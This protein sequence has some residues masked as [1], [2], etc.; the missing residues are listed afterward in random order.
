MA[1]ADDGIIRL[2]RHQKDGESIQAA[3]DALRNTGGRV[4]LPLG[5]YYVS[6]PIQLYEHVSLIGLGAKPHPYS[7]D[8]LGV[9]LKAVNGCS[10]LVSFFNDTNTR[11]GRNERRGSSVHNIRFNGN[12]VASVGCDISDTVSATIDGCNFENFTASGSAVRAGGALFSTITNNNM[13]GGDYYAL[14]SDATYSVNY[15][16]ADPNA[17]IYY[18]INV[19]KFDN[20]AVS[21]KRGIRHEGILDILYNDFEMLPTSRAAIDI[22][23]ENFGS[24]CEI[25]GN[26]FEGTLS[27]EDFACIRCENMSGSIHDNRLYGDPG[28][29]TAIKLNDSSNK[30]ISVF[31]NDLQYWLNGIVLP[32][33]AGGN[34]TLNNI[35]IGANSFTNITN[36]IVNTPTTRNVTLD[37][38]NDKDRF[39]SRF[40]QNTDGFYFDGP[41]KMTTVKLFSTDIENLDLTTLDLG[42]GNNFVYNGTLVATV[43]TIVNALPGLRFTV[44]CT[45]DSVITLD[46]SVFNLIGGTNYTLA[47]NVPL[48][49]VVD[50]EGVVREIGVSS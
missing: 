16:E 35:N 40:V 10:T 41:V 31:S 17:G 50:H 33:T 42:L 28:E 44:T 12:S 37:S 21:C 32:A 26:Y 29:H 36:Y 15:N 5:T 34:G 45:R 2:T 46:N 30:N 9:E 25:D 18:G 8:L 14:D 23:S 6:T 38:N 4:E 24:R 1:D 13:T 47:A 19:G 43:G 7:P 27:L 3:V 11:A 48:E 22:H 39:G 49:F 20:N